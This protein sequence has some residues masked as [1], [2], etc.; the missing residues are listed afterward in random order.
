VDYWKRPLLRG[1]LYAAITGVCPQG[2]PEVRRQLEELA[3]AG[4][5]VH[6]GVGAVAPGPRP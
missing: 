5:P 2:D 6:E 4:A 3:V 1:M